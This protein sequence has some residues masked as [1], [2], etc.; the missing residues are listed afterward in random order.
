MLECSVGTMG[1]SLFSTSYGKKWRGGRALHRAGLNAICFPLPSLTE[2]PP[3]PAAYCRAVEGKNGHFSFTFM[4]CYQTDSSLE[5]LK[6][7]CEPACH[8]LVA[9]DQSEPLGCSFPTPGHSCDF[10]VHLHMH[11]TP[12]PW[13]IP[14]R[15]I[16]WAKH[17][18]PMVGLGDHSDLSN[19][20]DSMILLLPLPTTTN[21]PLPFAEQDSSSLDLNA[22]Q[23]S[24]NHASLARERRSLG[25]CGVLHLICVLGYRL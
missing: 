10:A 5:I 13:P 11:D 22:T 15:C 2:L 8:I 24:Q 16:W 25:E 19:L 18:C 9:E 12:G 23:P 3:A 20:H 14:L 21:F 1:I 17:Q 7:G 6:L 4:F